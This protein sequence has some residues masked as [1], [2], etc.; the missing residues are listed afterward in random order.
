[1]FITIFSPDI[2]PIL[3]FYRVE[4]PDDALVEHA[5]SK[6]WD[7]QGEH[8]KAQD[9]S[10]KVRKED[11]YLKYIVVL[12]QYLPRTDSYYHLRQ[13][14]GVDIEPFV[15]VRDRLRSVFSETEYAH[16]FWEIKE[17]TTC[18]GRQIQWILQV[19]SSERQVL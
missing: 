3:P 14:H 10:R 18:N 2:R 6:I 9:A 13:S 11:L 19:G 15:T 8:L 12:F 17:L 7:E 16:H 4:I 1:M 5:I